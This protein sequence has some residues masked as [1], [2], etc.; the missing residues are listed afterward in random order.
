VTPST[1]NPTNNINVINMAFVPEGMNIHYQ[2]TFGLGE[3]PMLVYGSTPSDLSKTAT[4]A[5]ST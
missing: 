3:A 2:T 5:S 4:G 1:A